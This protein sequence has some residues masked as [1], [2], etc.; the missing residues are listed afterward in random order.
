MFS[1]RMSRFAQSLLLAASAFGLSGCASMSGNM[2][3]SSGM[4]YYEKGNYAAAS[5][6]FQ[7]A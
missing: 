4:G 1:T 7:M 2:A 6:E 3:N 5:R